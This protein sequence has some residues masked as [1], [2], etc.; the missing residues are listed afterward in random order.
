MVTIV[1]I[2]VKIKYIDEITNVIRNLNKR[3]KSCGV[4]KPRLKQI[5][6]W[7]YINIQLKDIDGR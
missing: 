5:L 1:F 2:D 6:L 7:V 4:G 3:D